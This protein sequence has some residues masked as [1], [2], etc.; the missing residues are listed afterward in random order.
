MENEETLKSSTLIGQSS[1]PVH[2]RV[3][4][5]P[6][7]GIVAASIIIRGV[8]FAG[9]QLLRMIQLLVPAYPYFVCK[10][11]F[12]TL[13]RNVYDYVLEIFMSSLQ[14]D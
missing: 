14:F 3:Y 13:V 2:Y 7:N 9:D 12:D 6:T 11:F 1:Y 5:L 10:E 8:F 4:H